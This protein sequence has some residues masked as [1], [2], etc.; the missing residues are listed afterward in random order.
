MLTFPHEVQDAID[1]GTVRDRAEV[2]RRLGF[3]WARITHPVDLDLTQLAPDVQERILFVD[4]VD[5][6]EAHERAG[7]A[8]RGARRELEG[9]A[10]GV[11]SCPRQS[12]RQS[13]LAFRCAPK[14]AFNLTGNF[15]GHPN[16]SLRL[17]PD[18]E[19]DP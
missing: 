3:T 18:P 4:A 16:G 14:V 8:G 19:A 15:D 9:A 6:V 7:A 12:A 10:G 11:E 1:R 2:A 5:G 13:A 17:R